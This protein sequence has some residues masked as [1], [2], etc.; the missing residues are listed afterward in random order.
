[1]QGFEK[2]L[3]ERV[4]NA[5][6]GGYDPTD[7]YCLLESLQKEHCKDFYTKMIGRIASECLK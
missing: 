1:M 4:D 6:R 7:L 3:K 2:N 5:M